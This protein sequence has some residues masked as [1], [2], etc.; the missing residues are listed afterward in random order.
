MI[1]EVIITR[2]DELIG[3]FNTPFFNYLLYSYD[4]NLN[5]CEDIIN[6]LKEDISTGKVTV[7]NLISTVEDYFKDRVS[8]LEKQSKMEY[9]SKLTNKEDM[10]YIKFLE[11]YDLTDDE[12]EVIYS[13]VKSRILNDNISDFEI[14]RYLE[15][16]YDNSVKQKT[17]IND[18]E[19]I[20]GRKY[21]TLIIKKA[22]KEYPILLN[23][24]IVW[25]ISQIRGD[26][27]DAV[28]FKKGIKQE[29][30][31]R[32]MKMSENKKAECRKKLYQFVEGSGD[33][34]SKLVVFKR[35]SKRDG[36]IIV[37]QIEEDISKGLIQPAML[38]NVFLTNR[39]NEYI[40]Q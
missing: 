19:W 29:F 38:D 1:N 3:D 14:K 23:S 32:C 12:E 24:D 27:L 34:F 11:K 22:K 8:E 9:L 13:K 4:L 18:L 40:R 28:E 2:L 15:Y 16:Y 31:K 35:L 30:L 33:S 37:K 5:E 36:Q 20:V 26:I 39:F 6:D 17:Y 25:I 21:D 10:Y 7:D